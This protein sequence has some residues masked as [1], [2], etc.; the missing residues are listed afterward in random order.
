MSNEN[1]KNIFKDINRGHRVARQSKLYTYNYDTKYNL[2]IQVSSDKDGLINCNT[3]VT[4]KNSTRKILIRT[5][6]SYD[7][8]KEM[9]TIVSKSF[10]TMEVLYEKVDRWFGI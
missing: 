5:D 9:N 2:D 1:I 3:W 8:R 6:N 7:L 10:E 4:D